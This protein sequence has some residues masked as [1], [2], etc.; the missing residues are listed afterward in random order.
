MKRLIIFLAFISYTFPGNSQVEDSTYLSFSEYFAMVKQYHPLVKQANLILDEGE[1]KLLKARGNF[2]PKVEADY[3]TK[4]Y[5][6]TEYY[7]NFSSAFKIPTWYGLEFNAKF[8]DNDGEYLNPQNTVPEDGLYSAGVSLSLSEGLFM[9]ERMAALKQAKLYRNQ[10][11]FKRQIEVTN[12][13]YKASIAYFEW[14]SAYQQFQIYENFLENAQ[15]RFYG[16]RRQFEAGDRPAIDTLEAGLNSQSRTLDLQQSRLD[17]KNARLNL[18]NFVWAENNIPLELTDNVVP[19]GNLNNQ[20]SEALA[21]AQAGFDPEIDE[22][23]KVR[24]LG[25]EI[26]MLEVERKLRANK[27][28]PDLDLEYNF[29]TS[30][31]DQLNTLN[32]RNYKFGL[33][34]SFPIFLRKERGDLQLAKLELANAEFDLVSTRLKIENDIKAL[35]NQII[36]F[37]EQNEIMEALVQDYS[38]MVEAE[39]RKFELG[40]SSLFLINSR[41]NKLIEARLKEVEI[42]TKLLK[43]KAQ[44]Y[45][46]L[47]QIEEAP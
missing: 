37:R 12:I 8:E 15:V 34:F 35:Q 26:D 23:P 4:D 17:L 1:M 32:N 39:E 6:A 21:I 9:S 13:L 24:S 44:L 25:Y 47:A 2:D 31:W 42:I 43:S 29:L 46:T 22:H 36:G 40:E 38:S 14:F 7:N 30:E 5:K 19:S 33:K 27:L 10:S 11:R 45:Q 28:L 3:N 20:V 18:S 16:V 41:E